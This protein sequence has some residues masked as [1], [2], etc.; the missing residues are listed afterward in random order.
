MYF[1]PHSRSNR[2]H[3]ILL[4]II[5]SNGESKLGLNWCSCNMLD[6]ESNQQFQM[7]QFSLRTKMSSYLEIQSFSSK[8]ISPWNAMQSS[9]LKNHVIITNIATQFADNVVHA[10]ADGMPC[11][12]QSCCW[13]CRCFYWSALPPITTKIKLNKPV[14]LLTR[15]KNCTSWP[16]LS[17]RSLDD[18]FETN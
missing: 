14:L 12:S 8:S 2:L 15:K 11:L 10:N 5:G 16:S 17:W 3:Y 18:V 1:A 4:V 9:V 6:A 13:S 7:G